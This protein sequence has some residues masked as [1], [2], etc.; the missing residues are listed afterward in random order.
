MVWG[1]KQSNK[2]YMYYNGMSFVTN[3][4]LKAIFWDHLNITTMII[5]N[6]LETNS[7]FRLSWQ[8]ALSISAG[9]LKAWTLVMYGTAT[10][11]QD[12]RRGQLQPDMQT[13]PEGEEGIPPAYASAAGG[14]GAPPSPLTAGLILICLLTLLYSWPNATC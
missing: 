13:Q 3:I 9:S 1:S 2:H 8:F 6:T 4:Y 14:V 11:P 12:N 7:F 5:F 10:H